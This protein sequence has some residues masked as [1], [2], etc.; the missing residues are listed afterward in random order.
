[1]FFRNLLINKYG[2][3]VF[4]RR[5]PDG[6]IYYFS[7]SDFPGLCA[8]PYNFKTP[9]GDTLRGFFYSY[10]N[11]R[12]DVLVIFDHGMGN[13][14]RAYM[15]EIVELCRH[16]YRVFAYDHTGCAESDGAGIRGLS[17]SLYDLDAAV[18]AI[19]E[20]PEIRG[21]RLFAIGHSWGGFSVM[22]IPAYHRDI[23]KIVAMSGFRSV[24]EIQSQSL[25]KALTLFKKMFLSAEGEKNPKHF[26]ASA[27]ENLKNTDAR[28]LI[29]HSK[30][31]NVV[32]FDRHF[33][34]LRSA[35]ESKENIR[36]VAVDGKGHN[37]NYT[38][39]AVEYK[40]AFFADLTAL[41]KKNKNLTDEQKAEF[42]SRYDFAAMSEQDEELWA[43]IFDFLDN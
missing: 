36:F 40:D 38:K 1:M 41:R 10:P 12:T 7:S 42:V 6:T 14:H 16:G 2:K 9:D 26:T 39:A 31:D 29:I 23:E 24:S 3:T 19:K 28:A 33:E 43:I 17:G 21:R 4:R 30:D 18:S 11:S 27:I 15:R 25:P 37:P 8:D 20:L 34:P 22:N 35:L 32:S 5:D 13:G